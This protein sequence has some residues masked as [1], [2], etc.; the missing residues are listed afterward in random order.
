MSREN[1]HPMSYDIAEPRESS[2]ELNKKYNVIGL[3]NS[4]AVK[5]PYQTKRMMQRISIITPRYSQFIVEIWNSGSMMEP[6]FPESYKNLQLTFIKGV[7]YHGVV[8]IK[9]GKL[10]HVFRL[11][12]RDAKESRFVWISSERTT[13]WDSPVVIEDFVPNKRIKDVS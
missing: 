11:G 2:L 13:F 4:D 12:Q 5:I 10:A 1:L 8:S 3:I 9:A 6:K 7:T